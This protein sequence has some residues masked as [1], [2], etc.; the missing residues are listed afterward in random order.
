M[1]QTNEIRRRP[2]RGAREP[3]Q[4]AE[5]KKRISLFWLIPLFLL[6]LAGLFLLAINVKIKSFLREYESVQPKYVA[7]EIYQKY[8]DPLDCKAV[9][10]DASVSYKVGEE[11]ITKPTVSP[12]ET[13]ADME[14]YLR[15]LVGEG[16]LSYSAISTGASGNDETV[17]MNFSNLSQYFVDSFNAQGDL[18]YIV[19]VGE[20]KIA[21]FTLGHTGKKS[22]NGYDE[23]GFSSLFLYAVPHESVTVYAPLTSTVSLN[24][25]PLD[26]KYRIPDVRDETDSGKHL[27]N[28]ADGV[29]YVAYYLEGLYNKVTTDSLKATD[30]LGKTQPIVYDEEKNVFSAGLVYDDE[31]KQQYADYVI[32][33]IERYSARMQNDGAISEFAAYFDQNSDLW[34]S[35]REQGWSLAFVWDHIGYNFTEQK[36]EEF[37]AYNDHEFSCH[38]SM[39][40]TLIGYNNQ[41]YTDHVDFIVYLHKVNGQYLIYDWVT[42]SEGMKAQ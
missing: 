24:G 30:R 22:R 10:R 39:L 25:V 19:K 14:N 16:E 23:Y 20:K 5:K 29:V 31:L 12:F 17:K 42:S 1:N 27:E 34:G 36:A 9:F 38:V 7:E 32:H 8:F 13:E 2:S 40:H 26:E 15:S 4:T 21:E 18:R 11:E 28:P 35:I 41:I 6:L 37:Y 3:G 33:A